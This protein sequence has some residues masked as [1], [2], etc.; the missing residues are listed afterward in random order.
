MKQ[1][2]PI[3]LCAKCAGEYAKGLEITNMRLE[4]A[5][6]GI[7]KCRECGRNGWGSSYRLVRRGK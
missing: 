6:D 4:R 1:D 5:A 7:V 3:E 2:K